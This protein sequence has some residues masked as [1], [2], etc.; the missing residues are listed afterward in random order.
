MHHDT[1]LGTIMHFM[2]LDRQAAPNIVPLRPETQMS[3]HGTTFGAI[4][5]AL[6]RC[7]RAFVAATRSTSSSAP[8]MLPRGPLS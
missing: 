6:L 2:E 8:F 4:S 5:A 7:V 1:P 3:S